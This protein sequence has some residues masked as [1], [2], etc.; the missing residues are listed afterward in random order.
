MLVSRNFI[1]NLNK[2]FN[3]QRVRNL[4]F[5][6]DNVII[7]KDSEKD[8]KANSDNVNSDNLSEIKSE[9][10][11]KENTGSQLEVIYFYEI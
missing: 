6:G 2:N 1:K 7:S 11:N 10:K 4:Y 9:E 5:G 8:D 3:Y